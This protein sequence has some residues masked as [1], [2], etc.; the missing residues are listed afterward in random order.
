MKKVIVFFA[1]VIVSTV[2]SVE[3]A[4][5]EGSVDGQYVITDCGTEHWIP[6]SSSEDFAV[7]MQEA[8]T[9]IDC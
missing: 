2:F 9:E 7:E 5:P 6:A 3:A 4:N 8:W 1:M